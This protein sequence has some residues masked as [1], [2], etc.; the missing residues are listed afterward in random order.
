LGYVILAKVK[1][2]RLLKHTHKSLVIVKDI[3][4]SP[5]SLTLEKVGIFN[6]G[7]KNIFITEGLLTSNYGNMVM[8]IMARVVIMF[9]LLV[10]NTFFIGW[11]DFLE[12]KGLG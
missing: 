7:H 3:H 8:G 10:G 1:K 9:L 4:D 5:S 12:T 2:L 6:H 11:V